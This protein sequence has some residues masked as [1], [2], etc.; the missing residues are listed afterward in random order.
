M[1]EGAAFDSWEAMRAHTWDLMAG[2][3][4]LSTLDDLYVILGV[5]DKPKAE[6]LKA[7]SAFMKTPAWNPAPDVLKQ[8][9]EEALK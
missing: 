6:K 7:L 2:D 9:A 8:Q 1:T 5:A 4:L 3:H